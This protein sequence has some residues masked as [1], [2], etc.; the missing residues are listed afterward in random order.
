MYCTLEQCSVYCKLQKNSSLNT[1]NY[2]RTV[3]CIFT[4]QI[5]TPTY[6]VAYTRTVQCIPYSARLVQRTLNTAHKYCNMKSASKEKNVMHTVQE[7]SV[8]C[9]VKHC[10]RKHHTGHHVK[11]KVQ[12]NCT[13]YT[14]Q[15][16]VCGTT[17]P[18]QSAKC[19]ANSV[20]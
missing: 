8:L 6:T 7:S 18:V 16:I 13:H 17:F 1:V 19:T 9:T 14:G 10:I 11:Y 2:K 15:C 20:Q 4:V 3:H 12:L 5:N